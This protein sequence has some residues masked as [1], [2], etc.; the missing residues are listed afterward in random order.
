MREARHIQ[1]AVSAFV[2]P[3]PW[4]RSI[5]DWIMSQSLIEHLWPLIVR[6]CQ[7]EPL[8]ATY[9]IIKAH[10]FISIPTHGPHRNKITSNPFEAM[11]HPFP[12]SQSHPFSSPLHPH[13]PQT[14]HSP[15][16]TQP[17]PVSACCF[18][19]CVALYTTWPHLLVRSTSAAQCSQ[20]LVTP[21]GARDRTDPRS[22]LD[23]Y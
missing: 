7:N 9:N 6:K 10:S 23:R 4:S 21:S 11:I 20:P 8:C 15:F 16:P 14:T 17:K 2:G 18:L 5:L 22:L 12:L 1:Q 19:R 13:R 3:I